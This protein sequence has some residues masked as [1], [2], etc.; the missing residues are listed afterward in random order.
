VSTCREEVLAAFDRLEGSSGR[1]K[2]SLAEIVSEVQS[3]G[4]SYRESTI[5]THVSSRLCRDAP[6]N[7][8][9]VYNDLQR[10]GRGIYRRLR[11]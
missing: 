5:R 4:T 6:V 3:A 10:V 7:H 11:Q 1:R 8:A 9:A 2:F